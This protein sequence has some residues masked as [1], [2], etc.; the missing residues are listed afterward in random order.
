MDRGCSFFCALLLLAIPARA[1]LSGAS[2]APAY[3]AA[4]I[5]Q[6]ATQLSQTLAPNT[7]ATLYGTNLSYSTHAVTAADLSMGVLPTTL[8]QVTV[9]VNGI[10]ANLYYVS[11]GQI[12]FLIPYTITTPTAAIHVLRQGTVGP[13]VTVPLAIAAPGFFQWNGNLALA[14]HATGEL[15][16]AASPATG[17]E[18]I[19]L[20]AA[21]LGRTAPD[22][23]SGV[24]AIRATPIL[25]LADFQV[26]V[27][28]VALP[29]ANVYY[30]GI[31][32]GFSGLYQ[33]NLLLPAVL[34][35]NPQIQ[36]A[37]GQ[38][39]SPAGIVLASQ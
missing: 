3:T 22:L 6:A 32:P 13:T 5:V 36:M 18:V 24:V 27:N 29:S 12:N 37:M 28:G 30:A 21:G 20:F 7:I 11:P 31:A 9:S 1:D 23:G 2:G 26:L 14:V 34:T 15:I 25:D 33:I 4:G 8:E 19:I 35:T 16:S 10:P 17:G 39:T 38:Q